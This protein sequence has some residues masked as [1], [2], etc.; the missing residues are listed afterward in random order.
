FSLL[1]VSSDCVEICAYVGSSNILKIQE[2]L[3]V[4]SEENFKQ[5]ERSKTSAS[6]SLSK[7]GKS[8][9]TVDKRTQSEETANNENLIKMTAILGIGLIS[10][11]DELNSE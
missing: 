6:S 7:E 11:G 10:V 9:K 3:K 5:M 4:C 8:K 1:A 2:L